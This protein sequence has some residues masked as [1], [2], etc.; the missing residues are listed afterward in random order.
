MV[1]LRT[2]FVP[3]AISVVHDHTFNLEW[4]QRVP[5]AAGPEGLYRKPH[6][7]HA[8]IYPYYP[9]GPVLVAA[10]VIGALDFAHAHL[11][12]GSNSRAEVERIGTWRL[13]RLIAGLVVAITTAVL[14]F[15]AFF[16]FPGDPRRRRILATAFA[17]TFA[18]ATD[19]WD[20]ASRAL[21][22]HGPSMLMLSLL[23][24]VLVRRAGLAGREARHEG[25]DA[26][27]G[28]RR[29]PFDRLHHAAQRAR[30]RP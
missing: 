22:Q 15:V 18:F 24:L 11:G 12:L 29:V 5:G 25:R 14:W 6:D 8:P 10:P 7:P 9:L 26:E 21:W 19:A 27:P 1:P 2:R 28:L 30:A 13:E 4:A 3:A 23:L 20:T 17:L 16:W